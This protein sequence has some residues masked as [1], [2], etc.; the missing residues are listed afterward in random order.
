MP[1]IATALLSAICYSLSYVFLHKG[2]TETEYK[3][4]GL[5]P[6]LLIGTVTIG[7]AAI[8]KL[9]FTPNFEWSVMDRNQVMGYLICAVSGLVGT[10]F[11]R[12]CL[13]AAIRRLGATRGV[14]IKTLETI[15]T[16]IL[17]MQFL[18]E[19]LLPKDIVGCF[20]LGLGLSLL[21]Y[22]QSRSMHR[23]VLHFGVLLGLTAV[24]FQG[25]GHFMRKLGMMHS[26]N[27]VLGAAVDISLAFFG[28]LVLLRGTG[29]LHECVRFYFRNPNP[30]I[31]VSGFLSAL[32][33]LLF[34]IS[35]VSAPLSIVAVIVGLEPIMVAVFS[36]LFLQGTEKLTWLTG[37]YA[38]VTAL[39]VVLLK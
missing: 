38:C 21:I 9:L 20:L 33:V 35:V 25:S 8:A 30:Y 4:N 1:G 22:E 5:F 10:L 11:G 7:L 31:W 12:L 14:V 23:S 32:G 18:Q 28:Y 13:Y 27:P 17:A 16:L 6:V 26:I 34:F 19:K 15:V 36:S 24:V 29:S 3:D 39:G 37:V 2:H